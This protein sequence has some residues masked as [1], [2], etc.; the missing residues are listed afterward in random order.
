M[1]LSVED[2]D[3]SLNGRETKIRCPPATE[4]IGEAVE[5]SACPWQALYEDEDQGGGR[6]WR[7]T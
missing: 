3:D 2:G 4:R 5:L 1:E 7:Q 6:I